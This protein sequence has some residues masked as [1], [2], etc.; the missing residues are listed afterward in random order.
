[1]SQMPWIDWLKNKNQLV[2]LFKDKTNAFARLA[3]SLIQ[4]RQACIKTEGVKPGP[5][6]FIDRFLD[7]QRAYPKIIDDRAV[8][9]CTTSNV[10]A[11][12]D[13]VAIALRTIMY[14]V[15]RHPLIQARLLTE[16]DA[17][18][19]SFPVTWTESQQLPYLDAVIQESLRIHPPVGMVLER[20]VPAEGLTMLDG[21]RIPAG[22]QVGVHPW[23]VHLLDSVWGP[24]P[25]EFRPERWLQGPTETV[26]EHQARVATM[27][28]TSLAF[29]AGSRQCMGK[30]LSTVQIAKL[31]PSLFMKYRFELVEENRDWNVVC[32]WFV[33]QADIDVH[34]KRR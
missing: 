13:T 1:M 3:A 21:K 33:R 22:V 5:R 16:I 34:I 7:A 28:R 8:I 23:A 14:M 6:L 20:V 9:I 31:I 12:S 11:G 29:R 2:S 24:E 19:L 32:S 26:K 4:D 25:K 30:H 17:A 18:S 10:V 27:K 15:L